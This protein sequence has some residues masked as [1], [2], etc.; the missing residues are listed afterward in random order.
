[1][2]VRA[3]MQFARTAAVP[4]NDIAVRAALAER[5]HRLAMPQLVSPET[6]TPSRLRIAVVGDEQEFL[7]L[8]DAWNRLAAGPGEGRVFLTHQWFEAAWAWRRQDG[9][10]L[11]LCAHHNDQLVGVLPLIRPH[12]R[13]GGSRARRLELLTVPDTQFC[14]MIA[15]PEMIEPVAAAFAKQLTAAVGPWHELRMGYLDP[16]SLILNHLLPALQRRG[17]PLRAAPASRNLYIPLDIP[18]KQYYDTRTRSLKKA[19]NLAANR[20]KKAGSVT[21]DAIGP[22]NVSAAE[23]NAMLETIIGLSA[24]SWKRETGNS[25]DQPGPQAF[26]RALSALAAEQGWLSVWIL[27]LD[28]KPLAMEYQLVHQGNVYALRA[29][30]EANCIEL[31]PGSH[32]SHMLLQ[33]HADSGER[34]RY[35]MGPG[36]NAYKTRWSS[37]G[38]IVHE[39][40][41]YGRTVRGLSNWVRE[42]VI[43]PRLRP[44]RDKLASLRAGK[45]PPDTVDTASDQE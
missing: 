29:D 17:H 20:L 8:R 6:A 24:G 4:N 16:E 28:G 9:D 5:S 1:M 18:W 33:R 31:S 3:G 15:T 38:A 27:R 37:E 34:R 13:E 45:S 19:N 21:I 12:D 35:Y 41:V 32:L 26:I 43:K 7:S 36:E 10:L 2:E 44:L 42:A 40:I 23:T 39:A 11:I 14:D 22:G 30:F 25:L